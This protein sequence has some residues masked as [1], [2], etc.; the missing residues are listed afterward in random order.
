MRGGLLF[1]L[2]VQFWPRAVDV[3]DRKGFCVIR[4]AYI[5]DTG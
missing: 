5:K 1:I 4:G 2:V 3:S